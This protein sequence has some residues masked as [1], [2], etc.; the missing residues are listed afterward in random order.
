MYNY[1]LIC[2]ITF[3][4]TESMFIVSHSLIVPLCN[5]HDFLLP[6]LE[7]TTIFSFL[8]INYCSSN[9]PYGC[10]TTTKKQTTSSRRGADPCQQKLLNDT[11]WWTTIVRRI[12]ATMLQDKD[13]DN[14]I[15]IKF[16]KDR[17]KKGDYTVVSQKD[18]NGKGQY[19][20]I[21]KKASR[22]NYAIRMFRW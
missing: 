14:G 13:Q 19:N 16:G 8:F 18:R 2:K 15:N 1:I 5:T 10:K 6:L 21:K 3:I 12:G 17:H 22:V 9:N 7:L 11:C 4:A 20:Y